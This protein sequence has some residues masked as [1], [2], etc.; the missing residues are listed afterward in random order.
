M[1]ALVYS[2]HAGYLSGHHSSHDS[3][4]GHHDSFLSSALQSPSASF[5]QPSHTYGPPAQI[6]HH[7]SGPGVSVEETVVDDHGP[8][9]AGASLPGSSSG[10]YDGSS[11]YGNGGISSGPSTYYGTP[12]QSGSIVSGPGVINGPALSS[13][14]Y[15]APSATGGTY[16]EGSLLLDSTLPGAGGQVSNTI[17]APRVIGTS[18]SVGRPQASAT[19]YELQSV[20]QN[21]IRRIPVEVVR[22]VQVAVPQP[23]PVPVRHEVKVPVP[24]PYPVHV[25]VVKHV[26]YP[27][28]KTQHVEVERPVPYE[29]V[30]QVPVEVIRKVHV[31]VDRPYEVIKKIHVPVEKHVEV[32]VAVWK[33]Y[34]IHV[35]KHVTHYKKKSC[36]W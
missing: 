14:D 36:C 9:L 11:G 8:V 28:Y 16:S 31:P 6:H 27:V 17:G 25:D 13:S 34:P 19:R 22:H 2:T 21:V 20:V 12:A 33:P 18:V 5:G 1:S 32:P 7:S 3:H 35:I 15:S 29:V 24:Q 23:V 10:L 4:S 26:P 30:K